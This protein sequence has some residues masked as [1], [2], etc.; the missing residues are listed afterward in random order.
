MYMYNGNRDKWGNKHGYGVM[1]YPSGHRYEGNYIH[2]I[3]NGKGF[4]H[5]R[6]NDE[7]R[8]YYEGNEKHGEGVYTWNNGDNYVG[9]WN[10][11][12]SHGPGVMTYASGIIEKGQ[13]DPL[14]LHI[15]QKSSNDGISYLLKRK[16]LFQVT[17]KDGTIEYKY[18]DDCGHLNN[19]KTLEYNKK[20][21]KER[22]KTIINKLGK[23]KNL[24]LGTEADIGQLLSEVGY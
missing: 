12:R 19:N 23:D 4:A 24:A 20:I 18:Y 6:N 3:V 1:R 21:E 11:N 9:N 16:G 13:Q 22:L 10:R 15:I 2:G 7:Y 17:S 14:G 5:F 8:G